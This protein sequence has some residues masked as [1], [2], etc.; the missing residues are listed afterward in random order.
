MNSWK[1]LLAG[2]LRGRGLGMTTDMGP[3]VVSASKSG[4][5]EPRRRGAADSDMVGGW[6][7]SRTRTEDS[8]RKNRWRDRI[9]QHMCRG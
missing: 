3:F 2:Q 4:A 5:L 9:C 8:A 6:Q 7:Q 1:L